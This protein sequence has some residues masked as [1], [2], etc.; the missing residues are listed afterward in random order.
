MDYTFD[1]V[2]EEKLA[3][4]GD[5]KYQGT[6]LSVSNIAELTNSTMHAI[7][8]LVNEKVVSS[9]KLRN[10]ALL[11]KLQDVKKVLKLK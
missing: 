8:K 7:Q 6:W 5:E 9:V 11:V 1:S 2:E 3:F 10:T 4:E